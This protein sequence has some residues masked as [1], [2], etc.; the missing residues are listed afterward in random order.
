MEQEEKLSLDFGNGEIYEVWLEVAT[1]P[2]DKNIKVCVFTEKEEEIWKLFELTTDMGIP[3]E[4]NQTFLLPGYDLEQI[5]E[6]VKKNGLG[7]LKEEICCSGCMEYPLFEFQEETLKK[8]DPEDMQ[9]M[10]RHTRNG[11]K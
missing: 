5:V 2:A 1:Y 3:L 11:E 7:Q 8:L 4:K 6:F 10:S 9:P